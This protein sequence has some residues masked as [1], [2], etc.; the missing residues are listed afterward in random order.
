V[1][2]SEV[3]AAAVTW[4]R[5]LHAHPE[6]SFREH[7]TA[8]YIDETL[9]AFGGSRS[10]AR[11]PRASS[12]GFAASGQDSRSRFGRTSTRCRSR[13]RAAS[14]SPR[15]PTAGRLPG[16]RGRRRARPRSGRRGRRSGGTRDIQR[17]AGDADGRGRAYLTSDGPRR[18]PAKSHRDCPAQ[19][20]HARG[21]TVGG[22][23]DV[24]RRSS[25]TKSIGRCVD[26]RALPP[27]RPF[28]RR[29]CR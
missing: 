10:S 16:D 9:E 17:P 3:A 8:R 24:C 29:A 15:A 22:A 27:T 25:A 5:H 4:R 14:R 19:W 26:L 13:R 21:A 28:A 18:A 11:P 7:E 2:V 23:Y 12:L 1:D 6:L 20:A